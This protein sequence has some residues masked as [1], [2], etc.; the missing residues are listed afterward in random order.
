MAGST[1]SGPIDAPEKIAD[2]LRSS[3]AK[4]QFTVFGFGPEADFMDSS[5]NIAYAFPGGLGLPD[6][7]YYLDADKKDKLEAYQ[8]HVAKVLELSGVPADEAARQARDV[9]AFETRLAKVSKSR[10]EF[11]R[12]VSLYYNPMQVADA[13]KLTPNFPWTKF[14]EVQGIE[15]PKLFS[16]S[17]PDF[18]REVD[19]MLVD[20][21]VGQWKSYLRFHVVDNA[22]PYLS[23]EFVQQHFEFHNKTL[24]GQKEI[25]PRWKR[26]LAT[27]NNQIDEAMGQMYVKVAFPPESK[28]RM[29]ALVA[30]LGEAL[31]ARIAAQELSPD[32]EIRKGDE[33]WKALGQ[34]LELAPHFEAAR[35]LSRGSATPPSQPPLAPRLQ[36]KATLI[37]VGLPEPSTPPPPLPHT[38]ATVPDLA[39]PPPRTPAT[40]SSIP[41]KLPA[42]EE[43]RSSAITLPPTTWAVPEAPPTTSSPTTSTVLQPEQASRAWFEAPSPDEPFEYRPSEPL[44][45]STPPLRLD[46]P[47]PRPAKQARKGLGLRVLIPIMIGLGVGVGVGLRHHL[48]PSVQEKIASIQASLG[49][50]PQAAPAPAA[51]VDEAAPEVDPEP[52]EAPV[53]EP[54]P[55]AEPEEAP[56]PQEAPEAPNHHSP[57]RPR[58]LSTPSASP[59]PPPQRA[60]QSRAPDRRGHALDRADRHRYTGRKRLRNRLRSRLSC[61]LTPLMLRTASHRS[62]ERRSPGEPRVW[63]WIACVLSIVL[64]DPDRQARRSTMRALSRRQFLRVSSLI[65]A[66]S[67]V[68]A[69]GPQAPAPG[70]AVAQPTE[71]PAGAPTAEPV[72]EPATPSRYQ[73]APSLAEQVA[74]GTLPPVEERLPPDPVVVTPT[75]MVGTYGGTLRSENLAP[76]TTSDA[77]ILMAT[78]FTRFSHD[79]SVMYPE[80]LE[81]F[82]FNEDATS[83]TMIL[84]KGLKW[85]DGEPFGMDDV[86]FYLDDLTYDTDF[87]PSL[88]AIWRTGTEPA[89]YTRV[90]DYTLRVDFAVPNPAFPVL[91]RSGAPERPYAPKHY[92]SQFHPKYNP[93]ADAEAV[94]AGY[95]NWQARLGDVDDVNYGAQ[96]VDLPMLDPWIPVRNDSQGM[97]FVR[98]PYYWKVDTEGKQ[99]PYIDEVISEY[100]G[101]LEVVNLKAISGELSVA[102][103]DILLINY[104][105]LKQGEAQGDYTVR[106]AYSERGADV[107]VAFN[108]IHP[109]PVLNE[110]F[111]D[112][113]FRRAMSVAINRPEVNNLVFLDQGLPWQATINQSASFFQQRW[114]DAWAEYDPDLANQLLDEMG[115][116][117]RNADGIRLRPDGEPLAFMLEYLPHE[118]P[119]KE[120]CELVVQ[121]WQAV[122]VQADAFGR[123]RNYLIERLNTNTHDASGWHCDRLLER[124]AW[125]YGWNMKLGPVGDSAVM[126]ARAWRDWFLSNGETGVEPPEQAKGMK[127]AFDDWNKTMMGTPEYMEA[128]TKVYDLVSEALWTIGIVAGAPQPLVIKK[129]L[130]NIFPPDVL[131]GETKYWWGAANWFFNPTQGCQWFF[132]P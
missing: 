127:Q 123:E 65:A 35:G 71:P 122:G 98:N 40:T 9:M 49:L 90:D 130:E 64:T 5:M 57:S 56:A 4:G 55:V 38:R 111:N 48:P 42:R 58:R 125:T 24:S 43:V 50:A 95:N 1:K 53:L 73:E 116:S 68:A 2:Y 77:Q 79:L 85:S 94:A 117:E 119:K 91:H 8:A 129:N 18:F 88:N 96:E 99:L 87:S 100:T 93:N 14:F 37:G 46:E 54:T 118:G 106:L 60:P 76:E 126:F 30:N 32:D 121:Y 28:E 128:A 39:P 70:P 103:L 27:I 110:I 108:L 97:T 52:P 19:A 69:C 6:K 115:L 21:P 62:A 25:K 47:P 61:P 84:R 113:R 105:L 124:A 82:Q 81:S 101:N 12:D 44:I 107:A 7:T 29:E 34:I 23:D 131:S 75:N 51:D 41:P 17:V 45:R 33:P 104:P 78:G 132:K 63:L 59:R 16:V 89:A 120:V 80:V 114:A 86:M 36:A 13:D 67:L 92:L 20:V 15:Q 72:A 26:V 102:G 83:C 11:S 66:G 109:D 10:A 31:K 22:S 112:V 3:A 74:A